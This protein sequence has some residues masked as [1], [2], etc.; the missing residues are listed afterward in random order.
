VELS[1]EQS[2]Q[3]VEYG[4]CKRVKCWNVVVVFVY[5][6]RVGGLPLVVVVVRREKINEKCSDSLLHVYL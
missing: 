1:H 3:D 5:R 6:E 2:L 4:G